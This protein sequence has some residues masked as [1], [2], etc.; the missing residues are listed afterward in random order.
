[1]RVV[2]GETDE[3]VLL[4]RAAQDV[5][6]GRAVRE[7]DADQRVGSV[8]RRLPGREIDVHPGSRLFVIGRDERVSP[9]LDRVV[10]RTTGDDCGAEEAATRLQDRV[11]AVAAADQVEASAA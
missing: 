7:V 6:E 8:P 3:D 11:V 4:G 1:Q 10:A 5:V 2:S 9:L